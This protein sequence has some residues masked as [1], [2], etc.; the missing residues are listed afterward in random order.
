VREHGVD[1]H[2]PQ[3]REHEGTAEPHALDHGAG[4]ERG[5]EDAKAPLEGHEEEVR[6]VAFR[7]AG[8]SSTLC[9]NAKSKLPMKPVPSLNASE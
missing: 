2:R 1:E 3:R 5:R 4:H 9:R 8:P 7:C 6:D